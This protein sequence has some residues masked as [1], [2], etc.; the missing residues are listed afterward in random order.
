MPRK[1]IDPDIN[2]ILDAAVEAGRALF[3]GQMK[4]VAAKLKAALETSDH[5]AS[6]SLRAEFEDLTIQQRQAVVAEAQR[7]LHRDDDGGELV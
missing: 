5:V 1:P 4:M 6:M 3:D 2:A 7:L